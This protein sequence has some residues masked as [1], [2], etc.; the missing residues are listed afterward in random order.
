MEAIIAACFMQRSTHFIVR[1]DVFKNPWVAFLLKQTHQ[2]PIYRFRDGY[3][4]LKKNES[5]LE[6]CYRKLEEGEMIIIFSEGLCIQEKRLRPIQ[7]GTAR[8]AFGAF[9]EKGVSNLVILPTGVN[10]VQGTKARTTFMGA[11]G[12]PIYLEDYLEEY[13][14]NPNKAVK[15]L[16]QSIEQEMKR[17]VVH[18]EADGEEEVVD[19]L[20]EIQSNEFVE[21]ALPILSFDRA[22]LDREIELTQKWNGLSLEER[23]SWIQKIRSY[24]ADLQMLGL[25]DRD[26]RNRTKGYAASLLRVVLL[27]IPGL[28]G[29]ILL[30]WTYFLAEI[31]Q[32]KWVKTPE[33]ITSIRFGI[34]TLFS[35]LFSIL[36]IVL[37]ICL[38]SIGLIF[39]VVLFPF[40]GLCGF[41]LIE[42][43]EDAKGSSI[44]RSLSKKQQKNM[45]CKRTELVLYFIS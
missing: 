31:L 9:E 2:I 19:Q 33:F 34:M 37:G 40:L 25:R 11:Y 38:K 20:L 32:K 15:H 44:I 36:V 24:S 13:R 42:A 29:I 39:S 35:I 23:N 10:Y 27:L 7:K 26:V 41:W 16:T 14:L 8:M 18:I 30:G 6:Y 21:V 12:N 1:G 5:T 43:W 3:S 28:T 4:N 45:D 22:R 17:H